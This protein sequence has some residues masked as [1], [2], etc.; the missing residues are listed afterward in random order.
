MMLKKISCLFIC[1]V[2]ALSTHAQVRDKAIL[3][4]SWFEMTEKQH[5]VNFNYIEDEIAV[6]KIIPPKSN[7]SLKEKLNY[8]SDKTKLEFKFVTKTYISVINNKKLDKPLC[9]YLIDSET[10]LPIDNA[11][12]K[13]IE[14]PY[15]V[16]TNEKGYFQLAQKSVNPIEFSHVNY[17]KR[18]IN[19]QDIYKENCPT[20]E[21]ILLKNELEEVVADVYLTKGITKKNDGTFEIKPKKFGLL[22]GL[23]EPDVLETLKQIPGVSSTEQTIS[24]LNVRGGTHDQNLILWNGVRLYQTGH[25]FGLISAL[26]PNL[27]HTIKVSKNGS[28]PFYGE[29][30]SSVVDISSHAADIEKNTAS[31]GVNMI[32]ADVYAKF[33]T[34]KTSNL[35]IAAGRSYT[36]LID[37]PTYKSYYNRIFQ[38]TIITDASNN[39]SS[40]YS[41]KENFYFYDLTGQFHKKI[42]TKNDLY[43]DAISISNL[44]DLT[45]SKTENNVFSSKY[46]CLEQQTLGGNLLLISQWNS[47]NKI[48]IG[49]YAS[50]YKLTSENEAIESNQVFNQQNSVLDLGV[51]LRNSYKMN[52]KVKLDYGYQ[53]NEI[54]VRNFDEV[55]TPTFSRNIKD[56]LRNHALI[57]ELEYISENNKIKTHL[58]FRGNYIEEFG[59]L[60]FEPRFQLSY[61]FNPI[62]QVEVLAEG[63]SQ[64]TSQ[65]IDLQRDFL[66][67][68][69]RR[70]TLSN[71]DNIPIERNKQISIGFTFKKHNWLINLDNFYKSVT[72][73]TSMSQ[74]FQNQLEFVKVDGDYTV[75]GSEILIQKQVKNFTTWLTYCLSEND[76]SFDRLAITNFDN[77]FEIKHNIGGALIY[78]FKNFKTALGAKWFTGKP[79][80]N[81]A[82]NTLYI[83]PSGVQEIAYNSP[84]SSFLSDY[85]EV[86]LS[87]SYTFK[88]AEKTK[89][90]FGFSIQNVLNTKNVVNQYYRINQTTNTIEKINTKSLERTPNA[91]VRFTF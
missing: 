57:G 16:I 87:G 63:K 69:K 8:I 24:N 55:T 19:Q 4:K 80:T 48:E 59:K 70:W 88:L 38:N 54:G 71:N 75:Y 66:G 60:L 43:I 25:F 9:G 79:T 5:H 21:L 14:S 23:T 49:G 20:I 37:S 46:S 53:Y 86:N 2:F 41:N 84:N 3:L 18:I 45:Q 83:N 22:P 50:F 36:D 61:S 13:I 17:E 12:V 32:N 65:I 72:G 42:G 10:K 47:K 44:L 33:K 15:T 26:N 74:G 7:L 82:S 31:I 34:S 30:V 64:T 11:N 81:P 51:R 76:Y 29:S 52:K 73:I 62:F 1:F 85:F 27:A 40:N 6:F 68:E 90:I 39:Q 67:I 77:N 28:S 35:E 56:I 78:D 58:G 89:L 91:F